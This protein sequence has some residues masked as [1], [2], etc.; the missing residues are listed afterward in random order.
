MELDS[1]LKK[2]YIFSF[3][4]EKDLEKLKRIVHI[5]TYDKNEAIF[6]EGERARGFYIVTSGKVKVYKTS[7]DGKER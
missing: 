1:L 4:P 5:K 6:N 3:L 7:T 2:C